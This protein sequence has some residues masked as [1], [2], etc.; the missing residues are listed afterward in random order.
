MKCRMIGRGHLAP[1][2]GRGGGKGDT[3]FWI[4]GMKDSVLGVTMYIG[5]KK[6]EQCREGSVVKRAK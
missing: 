4:R 1:A 5:G 6:E 2:F 3:D